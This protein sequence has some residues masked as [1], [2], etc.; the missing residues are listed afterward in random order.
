MMA[1]LLNKFSKRLILGIILLVV[2]SYV[3][4]SYQIARCQKPAPEPIP[5]EYLTYISRPAPITTVL[6]RAGDATGLL[7]AIADKV[8]EFG[9][10]IKRQNTK[11]QEIEVIKEDHAAKGRDNILIWL[12][13]DFWEPHKLVNVHFRYLRYEKILGMVTRYYPVLIDPSFK[14]RRVG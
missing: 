7:G 13:R 9:F 12:E 6:I 10:D 11:T 5:E 14:E 4:I 3:L 1:K 2:I 8:K